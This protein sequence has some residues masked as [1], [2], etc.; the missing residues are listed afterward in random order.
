MY[1]K[2]RPE[3]CNAIYRLICDL[4]QTELPLRRFTEI[5]QKQ[6]ANDQYYCLVCEHEGTVIGL[7]NLRFE[8]QLHHSERIAEVLEFA[9]DHKYRNQGIGRGL[10]AE[11]CRIAGQKGC[12]QIEAACNQTRKEAHRFYLREGMENLHFKFSRRLSENQICTQV[13]LP[14]SFFHDSKNS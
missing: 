5:Y 13:Q 12:A 14:G 10:L 1:R 2:S 7:L 9:V 3:D 6:T 8:E 11:G 4:E